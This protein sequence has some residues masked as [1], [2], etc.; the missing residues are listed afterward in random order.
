MGR[1]P[2]VSFSVEMRVLLLPCH[3]RLCCIAK[4]HVLR[5]DKPRLVVRRHLAILRNAI[6]HLF[7]RLGIP[8]KERLHVN[9]LQL[10]IGSGNFKHTSFQNPFGKS[11]SYISKTF[12]L[13]V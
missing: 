2:A 3:Q 12:H 5:L 8:A 4:H 10:D 1:K 11:L 9:Q 6:V 13:Q 7:R